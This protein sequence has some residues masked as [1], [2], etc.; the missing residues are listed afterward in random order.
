MAADERADRT[1]RVEEDA[2]GEVK[3]EQ[4]GE[5]VRPEDMAHPLS[6]RLDAGRQERSVSCHG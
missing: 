5:W 3:A 2:L 6:P 1:F 4:F